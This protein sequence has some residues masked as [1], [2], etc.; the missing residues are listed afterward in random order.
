MGF[1]EGPQETSFFTVLFH[2]SC[3]EGILHTLLPS[4]E[5]TSPHTYT[6]IHKHMHI[7]HTHTHTHTQAGRHTHH[8]T[9]LHMGFPGRSDGKESACTA[10]DLGW[11]DPL[12]EGMATHSSI[13]AWR[14]PMGRGN[15]RATAQEVAKSRT[16]LSD[17][18][19]STCTHLHTHTCVH[20][21]TH[22][23]THARPLYSPTLESTITYHTLTQAH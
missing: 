6:F 7:E 13:L 18:S 23:N 11:A 10:G 8:C 19:A 17:F 14:I 21:H 22:A 4:P 15:W 12:E 1:K 20:R 16:R 5:A 9:H 3:F 2:S